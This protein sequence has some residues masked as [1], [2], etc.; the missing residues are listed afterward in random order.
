[1]GA[2]QQRLCEIMSELQSGTRTTTREHKR[3]TDHSLVRYHGPYVDSSGEHFYLPKKW[4]RRGREKGNNEWHECNFDYVFKKYKMNG[5]DLIRNLCWLG[6][7]N[8]IMKLASN[9]S[10]D[11]SSDHDVVDLDDDNSD[12]ELIG[13]GVQPRP[14]ITKRRKKKIRIDDDRII[15]R[16]MPEMDTTLSTTLSNWT[17]HGQ[18]LGKM[19][20]NYKRQYKDLPPRS[21][22]GTQSLFQH[23]VR[24]TGHHQKHDRKFH[25][26]VSTIRQ[27]TTFPFDG[28]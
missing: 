26:Q 16:A 1:M 27:E 8:K 12:G 21:S 20:Q 4:W 28:W 22:K 3:P 24:S 23:H 15:R 6:Q 18:N 9:N 13:C 2:K 14:P 7:S 25:L 5:T 19:L 10:D 11:D 17:L